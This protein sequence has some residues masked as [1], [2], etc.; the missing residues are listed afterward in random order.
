MLITKW[1]IALHAEPDRFTF[2]FGQRIIDSGNPVW[3][4]T[5]RPRRQQRRI[6]FWSLQPPLERTVLPSFRR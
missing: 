3:G 5:N 4:P 1:A 2:L 6:G